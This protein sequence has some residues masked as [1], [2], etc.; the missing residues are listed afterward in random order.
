MSLTEQEISQFYKLWCALIWGI[1]EKQNIIPKFKKPVYGYGSMNQAPFIAIR[2]QL[3]DNP[4]WI[5]EFIHSNNDSD[6]TAQDLD[7]LM[8]WRKNFVKGRFVIMKHLKKHAIFMTMEKEAVLYGVS[9]ISGPISESVPYPLPLVVETVLL[10]FKDRVIYDSLIVPYNMSFGAG[11]KRNLKEAFDAVKAK[12]GIIEN[13]HMPPILAAALKK[14]S[15]A[16]TAA[17]P[18][19][20][21]KDVNIPKNMS[22]RYMEVAEI[23]EKFCDERLNG[24]YRDVCLK[25]L[26]KLCR[27]RPSPLLAGK[28]NSWA[29]G[30]VYAIGA[31]NFIFDKS[32]PINM[33]AGDIAGW[34][35]L[36]K[37]TAGGKANE[38]NKLLKINRASID[39]MLPSIVERNPMTWYLSVNGYMVDVRTMPREVQEIAYEKG[40]IPYIPADKEV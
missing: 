1:N 23:I 8:D 33:T 36:A 31:N 2:A 14:K 35:G 37:G 40:L 5:D 39:F 4:Q 15:K 20:D 22:A 13:M 16:A 34:F 30:I 21:T 38:I 19:V 10:P 29:C 3:W 27:K 32:Q 28:A 25:T 11:M 26:A 17:T 6:L 18:V 24:E 9:G 7:M 12:N